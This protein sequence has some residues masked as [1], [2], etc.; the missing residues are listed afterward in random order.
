MNPLLLVLLFDCGVA[1]NKR[2][3]EAQQDG[4][5]TG[6]VAG[7]SCTIPSM[8][9]CGLEVGLEVRPASHDS[10]ASYDTS[11]IPYLLSASSCDQMVS[12]EIQLQAGVDPTVAHP[13]S[14]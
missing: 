9:S 2:L 11:H 4:S 10:T 7:T 1:V 5:T 13:P 12:V 8:A 14:L 6:P 3:V